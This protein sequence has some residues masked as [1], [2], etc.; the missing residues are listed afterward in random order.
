MRKRLLAILV[1]VSLFASVTSVSAHSVGQ[2]MSVSYPYGSGCGSTPEIYCEYYYANT[3]FD[4][5]FY[6]SDDPVL[7]NKAII[8]HAH[9]TYT[10]GN[11]NG[12]EWEAERLYIGT[13]GT[14]GQGTYTQVY[15]STAHDNHKHTSS[16]SSH[17]ETWDP[18]VKVTKGNNWLMA[19]FD[20]QMY[21]SGGSPSSRLFPK[22]YRQNFN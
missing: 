5:Y 1:V 22:R 3:H 10:S 11:Q 14:L 18:N 4:F 8:H 12:D 20:F 9:A 6:W 7:A 17:H 13:D 2:Y 21:T 19:T 15:N 16:Y